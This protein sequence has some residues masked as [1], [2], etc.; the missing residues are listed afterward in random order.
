MLFFS[1]LL[2]LVSPKTSEDAIMANSPSLAM[3]LLMFDHVNN[4]EYIH[5]QQ[6]SPVSRSLSN[7]VAPF[8]FDDQ[9]AQFYEYDQYSANTNSS[10]WSPKP[11]NETFIKYELEH[12]IASIDDLINEF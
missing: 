9:S 8:I 6:S 12:E 11:I 1:F 10:Y 5:H 4:N 3:G 7:V 2:T